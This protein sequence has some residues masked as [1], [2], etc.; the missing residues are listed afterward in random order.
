MRCVVKMLFNMA[1]VIE[2]ETIPC[3]ANYKYKYA[4]SRGQPT[5]DNA[6]LVYAYYQH[7]MNNWIYA[8]TKISQIWKLASIYLWN[9]D[10]DI[11]ISSNHLTKINYWEQ[12]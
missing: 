11:L 3:N 5:H 4:I 2:N 1:A 9:Q 8:K 6:C 7:I 12:I 10:N